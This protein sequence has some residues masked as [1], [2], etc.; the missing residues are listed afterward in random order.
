MPQDKLKLIHKLS[1][2]LFWDVTKSDIDEH[3]HPDYIISRV[4]T[5]GLY[6]DWKKIQSYYGLKKIVNVAVKM[7]ELDKRTASF[8]SVLS[9]IP[10]IKFRC[11]STEQSRQKH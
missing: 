5:H 9:G 2:H 6:S 4:L 3:K 1:P 8:L 11:Y 10:K 7:R